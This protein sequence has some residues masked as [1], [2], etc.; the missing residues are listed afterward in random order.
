MLPIIQVLVQHINIIEIRKKTRA[1]CR[2]FKQLN[3]YNY[4][5]KK[6]IVM[7]TQ[8]I[9][10]LKVQQT[11]I[12]KPI[13]NRNQKISKVF[14]YQVSGDYSENILRKKKS[15]SNGTPPYKPFAVSLHV[16]VQTQIKGSHKNSKQHLLKSNAN[17]AQG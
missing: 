15:I 6:K 9:Y 3:A 7:C 4:N 1:F 11:I 14:L 5:L 12:K 17:R 8:K 13:G 2:N 10:E 16:F